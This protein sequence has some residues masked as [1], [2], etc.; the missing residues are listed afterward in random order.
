M[1][2]GFI[3][4]LLTVGQG[5]ISTICISESVGATWHPCG[6]KQEDK[7]TKTDA[8]TEDEE[9]DGRRK[10]LSAAVEGSFRRVLAAGSTDKC[11]KACMTS[12]RLSFL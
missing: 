5:P 8:K 1:L 4:L 11:G 9:G 7:A 3:S 12:T 10:L 6:K 2:L